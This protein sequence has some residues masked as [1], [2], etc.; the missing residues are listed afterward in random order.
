[1][2]LREKL[3]WWW[4]PGQENATF[5]EF[6][7]RV[8]VAGGHRLDMIWRIKPAITFRYPLS[9][10]S[11]FV[12]FFFQLM[13]ARNSEGICSVCYSWRQCCLS[14]DPRG[15]SSQ[16]SCLPFQATEHRH[17]PVCPARCSGLLRSR[18]FTVRAFLVASCPPRSTLQRNSVVR[19]VGLWLLDTGEVHQHLW[20]CTSV[21]SGQLHCRPRGVPLRDGGCFPGRGYW[22]PSPALFLVWAWYAFSLYSPTGST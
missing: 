13:V 8:Y 12:V 1:M 22:T 6:P 16:R 15:L 2:P 7:A 18:G 14:S 21:Q 19:E 9:I 4:R 10:Y 11:V 5:E 20:V 3:F 17:R